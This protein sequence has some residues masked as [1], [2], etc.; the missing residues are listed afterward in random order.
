MERCG[1]SCDLGTVLRFYK[2]ISV[3]YAYM[4][5]DMLRKGLALLLPI[6]LLG[7]MYWLFHVLTHRYGYPLGYLLSIV[8]YWLFWCTFVPLFLLGGRK[9]I[10]ELF[11]PFPALGGL[12]WK[13]HVALWWPICFPLSF[14][15]IPRVAKARPSVLVISLMLGIVIGLTEEILWRGVY[16]TLFPGNLWLNLI[17]PSIMFGLWHLAP[18][19]VVVNRMPGG[20][21]SFV[22]YAILLGV[23][24]AVSV[25]QTRSIAWGTISHIM[26]DS[27]GLGGLTYMVWLVK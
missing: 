10:I 1:L 8:I 25:N 14:I 18:Q 2:M 13:T 3:L 7:S 24:Y 15:F 27:L 11:H 23:T 4:P 26:H 12:T 22:V 19:S 6:I 16:M 5:S 9:A 17:Y 21:I 20:S